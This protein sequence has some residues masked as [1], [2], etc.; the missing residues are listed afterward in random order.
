M[1]LSTPRDA[2]AAVAPNERDEVFTALRVAPDAD[3]ATRSESERLL[4]DFLVWEQF[5]NGIAPRR[6]IL[7]PE[8]T[9]ESAPKTLILFDGI[10]GAGKTTHVEA[11]QS[12]VGA[13]WLSMARFA[14]AS[15]VSQRERRAHQLQNATLHRTDREFLE[16][17]DRCPSQYVMLEKFART[18]VE[19]V[20]LVDFVRTKGWRLTVVHLFFPADP[21]DSSVARQLARGARR[22]KEITAH[23]A[24]RRA[25]NHLAL[26]SSGRW[27]LRDL[28]V[29]IHRI[30]SNAPQAQNALRIR[31]SLG[32]DFDSLGW[33]FESLQELA[34][35]ARST[36]IEAWLGA[37]AFY[38]PFWNGRFGPIQLPTDLDVAVERQ[39]EVEP[40]LVALERNHPRK[41]WSVLC[42]SERLFKKHGIRVGSV[43]EAKSFTTFMHRAGVVRW[44]EAG[45]DVQL[46]PGVEP[47]LRGG[48]VRLNERLLEAL[49]ANGRAEVIRRASD[50]LERV[51]GC[52]PGIEVD[53]TTRERLGSDWAGHQAQRITTT[54]KALKLEAQRA[55]PDPRPAAFCRRGLLPTERAI[56]EKILRFHQQADFR[57]SAPRRPDRAVLPSPLQQLR[58][59]RARHKAGLALNSDE[60]RLLKRPLLPPPDGFSS[61]FHCLALTADDA[62]FREWFLS[63]SHQ[64]EPIGGP[65]LWL[66][67]MLDFSLFEPRLRRVSRRQSSMHQGWPL[68]KHLVA[69]VLELETDLLIRRVAEHHASLRQ[70]ELRLSMRTAMLFHDTGK[71]ANPKEPRRHALISARF[72]MQHRPAWFPGHL[73][74][75]VRWMVL[76]H[77][78]FG[79]FGRGLTEKREHPVGDYE[80]DL[81]LS[82]SYFGALDSQAV[83]KCLLESGLPLPLATAINKE[84]WRADVGSISAL[85]WLLP[86]AEL[87]EQL[88]LIETVGDRIHS[89]A[90]PGKRPPRGAGS[91]ENAAD[92]TGGTCS[93]R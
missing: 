82:T 76:T 53:P 8:S 68:Q 18:P 42:P 30:D 84:L 55:H 16:A 60:Q 1:P 5:R 46:A 58:E 23:E 14:E 62:V 12:A 75:L 56:A 90:A 25:L 35:I 21:V 63:Q 48:V 32:L 2:S 28:G 91:P 59:I 27:T 54:W 33:D 79:A 19:A 51:L 64:H 15:G 26:G 50:S 10:P 72:W 93:D 24:R 65:D 77:D 20:A 44:A 6:E 88:F 78:L 81:A 80:I 40:L 86:V 49:P 34:D 17:I 67:S 74:S 4:R 57:P 41:R 71:L 52:Y 66:Q 43:H 22:G 69:A 89:R 73:V 85:R 92:Q 47:G 7:R 37:G 31:R 29:P 39:D 38:R 3:E 11:L 9:T 45:L 13:S 83:R 70:D 87:V 36:G 61:W